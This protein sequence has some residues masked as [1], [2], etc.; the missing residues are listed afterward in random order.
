M[1]NNENM[2]GIVQLEADLSDADD[3]KAMAEV[4]R[5]KLREAN[6][7]GPGFRYSGCSRKSV[8]TLSSRN[9]PGRIYCADDIHTNNDC[10]EDEH[11]LN[12]ALSYRHG[13]IVVYDANKLI[14]PVDAQRYEFEPTGRDAIRAVVHLKGLPDQ[15]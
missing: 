1:A 2:E 6:L 13:V 15:K 4:I 14:E 11:P 5:A 9:D 3:T 7:F 12:Y 10:E 8:L